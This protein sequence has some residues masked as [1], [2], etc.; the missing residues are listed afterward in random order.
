MP[1]Q[2]PN[3]Y[4][5]AG[6]SGRNYGAN[7]SEGFDNRI[8]LK[9]LFAAFSRHKRFI[10]TTV[11]VCMAVA[12]VYTYYT[13]R[14]YQSTGSLMIQESTQK[15]S[16]EG[17]DLTNLLNKTYGIGSNSTLSNEMQFLQSR[18]ISLNMAD[19]LLENPIMKNGKMYPVLWKNYP[20]DSTTV[21][22]NTVAERIRRN[23][24]FTQTAQDADLVQ[25]AYESRSPREAAH[26]VDLA[27]KTYQSTSTDRN[28]KTAS[29]AVKFLEEERNR[30]KNKLA[31]SEQALRSFMNQHNVVQVDAQTQQTID[32]MSQLQSER[33]SVKADLVAVN[34]AIKDYEKRLDNIKPGL[35]EQYSSA[36]GATLDRYQY[37]LAE[38]QT[39]KTLLI[40]KNPQLKNS[41]NPPPA[42]K[43]LNEQINY[44]KGEINTLTEE[45][46]SRNGDYL[47]IGSEENASQNISELQQKLID[48]KTQKS[49]LE[50]KAE[51]MDE[52]LSEENTFFNNLPDNMMDLAKLKRDRQL[53]EQMYRTVSEQ[54]NQMVMWQK[55]QFGL[56][57]VIDNGNIPE[58][59]VK[60][61][62]PLFLLLS[63]VVGTML[64]VGYLTFRN[65]VNTNIDGIEM[66][67][68]RGYPVLAIIPVLE[69]A[70][71]KNLPKDKVQ[72]LNHDISPHLI[73]V[74]DPISPG[75]EAFR[76]MNYNV[77]YSHPGDREDKACQTILITSSTNSE[78]K[79]TVVSNL[80][81]VLAE[82]KKDV[83][84]VDTDLGR[85][86]L[87][88]M[89]G[90]NREPGLVD[91][92]RGDIKLEDA[93][94]SPVVANVDILSSG[95]QS[96]NPAAINQNP[97]F[98]YLLE[99][100]K[101][102]YD[103]VLIDT[104]PY[105]IVTDAAPILKMVD[106]I[107]FVT[108]FKKTKEVELDH[109]LEDLEK[110]QAN[111]RGFVI[112]AFDPNK[113]SGYYNSSTYYRSAY[114]DYY[115]HTKDMM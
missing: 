36:S 10:L 73:S 102:N 65:A 19:K 38:L 77:V 87:H 9:S 12:L 60:P 44:I 58:D 101:M 105:G 37:K 15:S 82:S 78:G 29:S 28:R 99:N 57:R 106:D 91:V 24:S 25:V 72:V 33:Q 26:M 34:S 84:I 41:E 67:K 54:Y 92:I 7:S 97:Q 64:S 68:N 75:A 115:S 1:N 112:T 96:T 55:T 49:Q 110:I 47:G 17:S 80:G 46:T 2:E 50:A 13:P 81:V 74:L 14:I 48:L 90:V 79:T 103:Y 52:R 3:N 93:I 8:T 22:R 83:I 5:Q 61:N 27:M 86:N 71:K 42:L 63:V 70:T 76:R 21:D 23:L 108:R 94:Q 98:E 53:N 51:V 107:V 35:S 31:E 11:F 20:E 40:S 18:Q 30:L 66:L 16:D 32:R 69:K 89:F 59:P 111:I 45:M 39:Q 114:E 6:G 100:L 88:N 4:N 85:P 113:S 95:S 104:A 109:T 43:K 62:I 56:G